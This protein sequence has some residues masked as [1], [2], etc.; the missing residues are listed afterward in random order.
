MV[1][2]INI[3]AIP[4]AMLWAVSLWFVIESNSLLLRIAGAF[5]ADCAVL[6]SAILL[7]KMRGA[8]SKIALSQSLRDPFAWKTLLPISLILC[9]AI[10]N[11]RHQESSTVIAKYFYSSIV[12]SSLVL[13]LIAS[14][15]FIPVR[16]SQNFH[17]EEVVALTAGI[18]FIKGHKWTLF[19]SVS[20]LL[21]GW[22]FFFIYF[23]IALT[24]A[25]SIIFP[26][27]EVEIQNATRSSELRSDFA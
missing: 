3:R 13:W 17:G 26:K 6:F 11:A 24:L 16:A 1:W 20:V 8:Q 9:L 4:S 18:I 2:D 23:F 21:F 12:L 27:I 25:Q 7:A 14:V 22:P 10:Q 19:L 5:L 15:V